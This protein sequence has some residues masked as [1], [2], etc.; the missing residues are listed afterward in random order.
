MP[1]LTSTTYGTGDFS[2]LLNTHALR[3]GMTGVLDVST[4]TAGTHYPNGYFPS[5]LPVRIDDRD[6]IRPWADTAGA[7]LGFLIGDH[8]T[9]GVEDVNCAV[10]WHG[11]VK[12]SALPI[13]FVVPTTAVQPQFN[14]VEGA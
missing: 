11:A 14:L 5:M 13:A 9:N 12:V 4:F 6:V 8:K 3:D 7:K 10:L 1:G 2:A